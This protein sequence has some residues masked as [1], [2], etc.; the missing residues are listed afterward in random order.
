[1][2]EQVL[3]DLLG[4]CGKTKCNQTSAPPTGQERSESADKGDVQS[5]TGASSGGDDGER[6]QR[7]IEKDE[8][9]DSGDSDKKNVAKVNPIVELE[10]WLKRV[11]DG[12]SEEHL[13]NRNTASQELKA[14]A[15]NLYKNGLYGDA[16]AK[17]SEALALCPLRET[18]SRSVLYA[19]KAA[20]L[21]GESNNKEALPL[22]DR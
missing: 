11:E 5:D 20:A 8:D 18:K 10:E 21:M 6:S 2:K 22:L 14:D 4:D 17:Y 12:L 15:N 1:M 7:V 13:K 16:A 3:L 19:N 9:K